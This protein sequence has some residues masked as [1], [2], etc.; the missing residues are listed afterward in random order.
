MLKPFDDATT[1]MSAEKS[2]SMGKKIPIINGLKYTLEEHIK[3]NS[4]AVAKKLLA[5]LKERFPDLETST[6]SSVATLLDPRFM[7]LAFL[8]EKEAENAVESVKAKLPKST[9]TPEPEK[10]E[11]IKTTK[12]GYW[13]HYDEKV[14][15]TQAQ[16]VTQTCHQNAELNLHISNKHH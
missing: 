9:P 3:D 13:A 5:H 14:K 1:E 7:K 10:K 15:K 8:D 6:V 12:I 2:T 16:S 11:K 4:S